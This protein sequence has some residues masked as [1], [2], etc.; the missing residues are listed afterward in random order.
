MIGHSIP[1][2]EAARQF[3]YQLHQQEKIEAAKQR[4]SEDE[5]TYIPEEAEALLGLGCVNQALVREVGRR[6]PEQRIATVDQDAT[7]IESRKREALR[8]YEGEWGYQPMLAVWAETNLVLAD[9]FGDG[10][11]LPGGWPARADWICDQRAEE[12]GVVEAPRPRCQDCSAPAASLK[13][14][15]AEP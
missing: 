12:R 15:I 14:R 7:I 8:T 1:S 10:V 9:E 13:H 5:I 2:P 3:L 11:L 4:R 6:C